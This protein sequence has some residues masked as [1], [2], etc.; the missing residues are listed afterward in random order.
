[1]AIAVTDILWVICYSA[2]TSVT[3]NLM[4]NADIC[5]T[6]LANVVANSV[7][8]THVQR[9]MRTTTILNRPIVTIL[10]HQSLKEDTLITHSRITKTRITLDAIIDIA[11]AAI[12][13]A[14][15]LELLLIMV[16]I[17][18]MVY[19]LNIRISMYRIEA[20]NT[21]VNSRRWI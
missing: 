19:M 9:R 2:F 20:N 15:L 3:Q 6:C 12:Y 14:A 18:L 13:I 17:A 4:V 7:C 8:Y 1:M 11:K 10:P 16:L 5:A 21:L